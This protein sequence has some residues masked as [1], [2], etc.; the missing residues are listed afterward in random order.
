M[1]A[2]SNGTVGAIEADQDVVDAEVVR[3]L[4]SQTNRLQERV[5]ELETTVH[6]QDAQ[7]AALENRNKLLVDLLFDSEKWDDHAYID[8]YD[9]GEFKPLAERTA[10]LEDELDKRVGTLEQNIAAISDL[11]REK[12]TKE[13]KITAIVHFAT[14]KADDPTSSRV[15]LRPSDIQGVAGVTQRYSYNLIDELPNQYGFFLA[16]Q[17]IRQYGDL[18]IDKSSQKRALIVDLELLHQDD[19]ALNK[20][21]NRTTEEG[22]R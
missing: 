9:A 18:Q 21:N 7:V 1:S 15:T 12:T 17:D 16:K 8:Q 22:G 6:Q 10:A 19:V 2:D 11:G 14:N 5:D 4:V 13:E 20:F 3:D